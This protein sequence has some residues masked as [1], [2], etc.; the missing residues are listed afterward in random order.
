MKKKFPIAILLSLLF[1]LI[2]VPMMA[3]ADASDPATVV[4][5]I[6]A[7]EYTTLK[8]AFEAANNGDTITMVADYTTSDSEKMSSVT[9]NDVS[10]STSGFYCIY[11]VSEKTITLDLNGKTITKTSTVSGSLGNSIFGTYTNDASLTIKDSSLEGTGTISIPDSS[12]YCINVMQGTIELQS[13]KI[14]N[15]F[16][17]E[18]AVPKF[19]VRVSSN[20]TFILSGGEI[21][22]NFGGV[23]VSGTFDMSGG[24]ISGCTTS[25]DGGGVYLCSGGTFNMSG[26]EISDCTAGSN[27]G[28]VYIEDSTTATFNM[29]GGTIKG[30]TANAIPYSIYVGGV[31]KLSGNATIGDTATGKNDFVGIAGSGVLIQTGALTG[32]EPIRIKQE[33]DLANGQIFGWQD[34]TYEGVERFKYNNSSVTY[35]NP[36][37]A[38]AEAGSSY[39]NKLYW[40]FVE[41][42]MSFNV[43]GHGV[44]PSAISVAHGS[45][46]IAPA[47]PAESGYV[48]DGWYKDAETTIPWNFA[49]DTVTEAV[50]VYAKWHDAPEPT[51]VPAPYYPTFVPDTQTTDTDVKEE[52]KTEET[53]KDTEVKDTDTKNDAAAETAKAEDKFEKTFEGIKTKTEEA[54]NTIEEPVKATLKG[55]AYVDENGEKVTNS[56]VETKKG[57]TFLGDDGKKIKK[58][59]LTV[60]DSE[61][62]KENMYYAKKN[63]MIATNEVIKLSNGNKIYVGE[64]GTIAVNKVVTAENGKKYYAGDDGVL[65]KNELV[66][67]AKG[68]K[69]FCSKDGTIVTGKW[70]EIDG[71]KYKCKKNGKISKIVVLAD[72]K[73]N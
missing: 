26:G 11:I 30:C 36:A 53:Q 58:T 67:D 55:N 49:T 44:T 57:V 39:T 5:K 25:Y 65:K 73:K 46:A 13:G 18:V 21:T 63:G 33:A 32:T 38:A 10:E 9:V 8:E 64:D 41:Y 31:L 70:I 16:I 14:S 37:V 35:C 34:G 19:T 7:N 71:V 69:Y 24:T 62:G 40:K 12:C 42:D 56:F 60:T 47:A 54:V 66:T 22:N 2:S 72:K 17:T 51:P 52:A 1:C 15:G 45:T 6:G 28:A 20:G 27:A 61:T 59:V 43:N 23:S 29:T 50:T 4:A 48:F 68:N 3:S